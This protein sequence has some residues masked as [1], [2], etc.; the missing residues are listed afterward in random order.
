ML[1]FCFFPT[2]CI[3]NAAVGSPC[4]DWREKWSVSYPEPRRDSHVLFPPLLTTP[5]AP[6]EAVVELQSVLCGPAPP[7]DTLCFLGT[8]PPVGLAI[9]AF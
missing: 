9:T 2:L 5:G 8:P 6:G 3:Q 4:Q 7:K 1:V